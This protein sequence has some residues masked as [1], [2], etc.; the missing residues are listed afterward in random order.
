ML[1][2]RSD[3][4]LV[5]SSNPPPPA[6]VLSVSLRRGNHFS[7]GQPSR[8]DG[9]L[10]SPPGSRIRA[11]LL[12][13]LHTDQTVSSYTVCLPQQLERSAAALFCYQCPGQ[14]S[15]SEVTQSCP[16]L[17]NPMD[18]S[19][20]GSSVHGIFQVRILEWVVISFSRGSSQPRDRIQ[21]SRIVGRCFTV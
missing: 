17:C 16:T 15:E 3:R 8:P 7:S 6:F 13:C 4:D 19:L 18:C 14:E 5:Q 12:S 11:R 20:S 9:T 2:P 1:D 21:V 10:G